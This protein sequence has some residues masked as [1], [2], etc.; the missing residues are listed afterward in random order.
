MS[1]FSLGVAGMNSAIPTARRRERAHGRDR[2]RERLRQHDQRRRTGARRRADRRP[3]PQGRVPARRGHVHGLA[4]VG[5]AAAGAGA[6]P[7]RRAAEPAHDRRGLP[8]RADEE[9]AA[10]HV[11]RRLER[12]G[13]RDAARALSGAGAEPLRRRRRRARPDVR[14]ALRR[15]A[16]RLAGLGLDRA[17]APAGPDRRPIAAA[18]WGVA[19]ALFGFAET[20]WLAL[21][22]LAAAGR[23][24]QRQRRAARHDPLERSRPTR[25]G[26]ASPGSS[27]R[28]SRRRPPSG[29]S[30]PACVA[31]LTSVRFS[32][33]SGG[34]ALRRRYLRDR[35]CR[36]RA[37]SATTRA[38][39]ADALRPQRPRGRARADR[40]D[41][42]RRRGR[43]PHRRGRGVRP[44]GPGEP[45]LPRPHRA[46]RLD[47]RAARARLR[48]PLVRD[49][50]VPE[51]RLRGRGRGERRARARARADARARRDDAS[52]AGSTTRGSSAAGRAGSARRSPSRASTT[53]CALDRPPFELLAGDRPVEVVSGPRIGITR[54]AEL[55]WRY[56]EAGSRFLSRALR[57]A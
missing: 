24:R 12:D 57:P 46:E 17:R 28:R 37:S 53:A 3:R 38:L 6:R 48:L 19:I 2:D 51:P 33:V 34:L 35:P 32:I 22:L 7:R 5:L 45:R 23:G 29:T 9:G 13:L 31:S 40:R 41:A 39:P 43:R 1:I 15:R 47:V 10:R 50:L 18:L 20:L 42:A 21:L 55:P 49:P 30:R 44:R 16:R 14:R 26:A 52:G 8:L 56:A 4:L 25:S 36:P 27:S 11:P 54:G